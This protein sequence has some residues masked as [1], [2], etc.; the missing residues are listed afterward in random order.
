MRSYLDR[1][2]EKIPFI[3]MCSSWKDGYL[4]MR[5]GTS[6]LADEEDIDHKGELD[7]LSTPDSN[8][9]KSE[10]TEKDMSPM[11]NSSFFNPRE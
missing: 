1:I 6:I 3:S 8:T 7:D 5:H 4:R 9:F 2:R 11:D 10:E